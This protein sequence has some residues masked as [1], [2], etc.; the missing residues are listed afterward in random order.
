MFAHENI[1]FTQKIFVSHRSHKSHRVRV[2]SPAHVGL[3]SV[4]NRMTNASVT[5]RSFCEIC[6][7]CVR[8]SSVGV[9]CYVIIRIR[10]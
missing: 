8:K 2:A 7:T 10:I 9:N 6:E 4:I 1:C 5:M 3:P